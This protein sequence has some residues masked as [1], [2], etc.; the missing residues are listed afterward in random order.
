[1]NDGGGGDGRV[2]SDKKIWIIR[3]ESGLAGGSS[4]VEADMWSLLLFFY[5]TASNL[6]GAGHQTRGN[7]LDHD[8][9]KRSERS[10]GFKFTF[11]LRWLDASQIKLG[12]HG[13]IASQTS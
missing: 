10:S 11:G 3:T 12:P 8:A 2:C 1:M 5:H 6:K 4:G 7:G 13:I 9:D